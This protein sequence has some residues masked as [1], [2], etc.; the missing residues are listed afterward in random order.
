M[1]ND[2]FTV[3]L[4][5][6]EGHKVRGAEVGGASI[7]GK[8]FYRTGSTGTADSIEAVLS[9]VNPDARLIHVPTYS[10]IKGRGFVDKE[11]EAWSEWHDSRAEVITALDEKGILGNKGASYV[12]DIQNGGLFVWD[13][14]RIKDA[15]NSGSLVNGALQLEQKEI[16]YVLV[17]LKRKDTN[18]LN[19]IVHGINMVYAGDFKG[20]L[21]AS[22]ASDF[23][24]GMKAS[25]IVVT[26][27]ED[28]RKIPSGYKKIAEQRTNPKLII[29]SAGKRN[30]NT[31]LNQVE[32]FGWETFGAWHDGY[33]N[34]NT[35]RLVVLSYD[36]YGIL[37]Y[38]DLSTCGRSV[39]VAPE[40]LDAFYNREN[41]SSVRKE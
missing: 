35:G 12:L 6:K 41:I 7:Y 38:D 1:T 33:K 34:N 11:N 18:A 40:A 29:H 25:Y 23:T 19:Q 15:V 13:P 5:K 2:N 20:F 24:Q 4:D 27:V 30:L 37:G 8:P 22:T 26:P 32:K 3:I 9:S 16:D 10:L 17:A 28:A 14:G 39:G 31:M 21:E 36:G